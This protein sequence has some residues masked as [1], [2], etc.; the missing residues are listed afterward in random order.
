[1]DG[2][3]ASVGGELVGFAQPPGLH[4]WDEDLRGRWFINDPWGRGVVMTSPTFDHD[5]CLGQRVKDFDP[6][7]SRLDAIFPR[8]AWRDVGC[9]RAD[10]GDPVL[11]RLRDELRAVVGTDGRD[12]AQDEQSES[13]S[14][15][16][17]DLIDRI[18]SDS[19]VNSSMK[20][21]IV[22]AV[23]DEVVGP[24]VIGLL[25]GCMIRH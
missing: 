8:T 2:V 14:M 6:E 21:A 10:C 23:L 3:D 15:T 16:S 19:W 5:F 4:R 25:R 1:M 22:C 11:Y 9:L 17:V 13:T 24:N 20:H 12:A 7:V 18:A